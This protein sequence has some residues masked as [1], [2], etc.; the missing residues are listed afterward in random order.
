MGFLD[1]ARE[2]AE[3]ALEKAAP[4]LEKAKE[5]AGPLVE[6]AAERVDHATGGKYSGQI[7]GVKGKVE[8]ALGHT[9][10]TPPGAGTRSDSVPPVPPAPPGGDALKPDGNPAA[11]QP[12][13]TPPPSSTDDGKGGVPPVPPAN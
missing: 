12:P 7:D 10:E 5:K 8:G 9:S 11:S 3:N 13:A 1:K 6:K 4:H 2:A